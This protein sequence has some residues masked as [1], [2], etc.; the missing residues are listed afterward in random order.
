M[1]R[2]TA[3][4]LG[5]AAGGGFPQWNCRCPVC[6]LAWDADPRVQER[7]QTGLAV[8]ADGKRWTLLNASPDLREQIA[9]T[10][11]LQ[12]HFSRRESPI[13]A[14][15]LTGAEIDQVAGLL[16]LREAQ[17]F[18][19]FA[20]EETQATL[21]ANPVFDALSPDFVT[22]NTIGLFEKF[23]LP[24]GIEA[25]LFP[26]PGK[27][28]LYLEGGSGQMLAGMNTGIELFAGGARIL[29][30]PG[31]ASVPQALM[32]RMQR[33][34]AVLFDGT[35]FTDD[36]MTRLEVSEK[37]G[38][39]MGHMPVSGEGGS[40]QA[41]ASVRARKIYV[42]INNTNPMLIED[43]PERRETVSKGFEVA[44]DGMEI[45]L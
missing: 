41:L 28:P 18:S 11:E 6:A 21:K 44:H 22:R 8:S 2:L 36:E 19:I 39:R 29:F 38:L 35:L 3:I 33:A 1:P 13:E 20:T 10:N 31:A 12:P 14:V 7:T 16:H 25:E 40:L 24:G 32:E 30:V 4:V 45:A 37:T 26:V 27:V 5:S 43:S 9:R 17:S 15:V 34:N 23:L 42:H